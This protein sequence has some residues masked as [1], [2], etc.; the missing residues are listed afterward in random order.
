MYP[1]VESLRAENGKL[2]LLDYHQR[3]MEKSYRHWFGQSCPFDLRKAIELPKQEGEHKVRFL[4]NAGEY[5]TEVQ[6][7]KKREIKTLKLVEIGDFSYRFK[8]TN[9]TA[10]DA[11]F[12]QRG[13]CDDVL[14]I[15]EGQLTDLSYANLLL[16]DGQFWV[17]PARPL[18]EGVQ[19]QF[20]LDQKKIMPKTLSVHD[21]RNYTHFQW[22]NALNP[23]DPEKR[24]S[25]EIEE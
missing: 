21:L 8:S 5:A 24:I 1:L 19:R 18:L 9:R 20:L 13:Q 4:Y 12:A 25:L 6:A 23:F 2:F 3:R 22:I 15:K 10:I 11:A 16:W 17:T 7:Y 14:L